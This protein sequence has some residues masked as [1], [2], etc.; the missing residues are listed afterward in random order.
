M[1][2]T[3]IT[4]TFNSNPGVN[5]GVTLVDSVRPSVNLVEQFRNNRNASGQ[6]K[7]GTDANATAQNYV[8]A[9]IADYNATGLY[10]VTYIGGG[11]V[12]IIA[13]GNSQFTET[14]NSTAGAVTVTI[15]NGDPVVDIAITSVTLSEASTD[16]CNKIKITVNT[17]VT[18]SGITSPISQSVNTNPF[19]FDHARSNLSTLQTAII[20]TLDG[21]SDSEYIK[22]PKLLAS[23]FNIS[24]LDTPSGSSASVDFVDN[25]SEQAFSLYNLEYS[26]DNTN[27]QTSK[28]FTGLTVDTYTAYIRDNLGC[29][30]S[31]DFEIS[32]FTPNIIDYDAY[33]DISNVNSIRFK[34]DED[35]SVKR[36]NPMNTLSFEERDQILDRGF[37]Q[38]WEAGDNNVVQLRSNYSIITATLHDCDGTATDL[39]VEQKTQYMDYTD[40]R[41]GTVYAISYNSL[42]YI[43]IKFGSGNTYDSDTLVS[44]GT[45]NLDENVPYWMDIDEYINIEGVGWLKIVD[46]VYDTVSGLFAVVLDQ[47]ESSYPIALGSAKITSIYNRLDYEFHEF[48]WDTTGLDGFY[49]ITV[50]AT[51]IGYESVTWTSEWQWVR[52]NLP[53]HYLIDYYGSQ[54]NEI[55]YSTGISFRLRIPYLRQLKYKANVEQDIYVTDTSTVLNDSRSRNFYEFAPMP[56]PTSM[57]QKL[58]LVLQHDRLQI[59]GQTFLMEGE[60]SVEAIGV[61]NRY[62]VSA[63]LV[64]SEYTFDNNKVYVVSVSFEQGELFELDDQAGGFLYVD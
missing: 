51:H 35:H 28:L 44:N 33:F 59:E 7:I 16:P 34:K 31:I 32:A 3:Q 10:T 5:T 63:N 19:V 38:L 20:M 8:Q 54:N 15:S 62:K 55:N 61:T 23:F 30:I 18:A 17:N 13:S 25:A 64:E 36:K 12:K 43:A 24:T 42:S 4:V 26:L 58:V 2:N 46:I 1:A 39:P 37:T 40:V 21:K 60:P 9:F 6:C 48:T 11:V 52:S 56:L 22:I 50:N 45:Y 29:S 49:Y 41:D 27:W 57:A 14:N 47:L 53:K